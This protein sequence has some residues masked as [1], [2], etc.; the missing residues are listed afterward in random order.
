MAMGI[1]DVLAA[2]AAGISLTDTCVQTVKRYRESGVTLDIERLIEE[3]RITALLRIDEADLALAQFERTLK[4]RD[5]DLRHTLQQAIEATGFW[6]PFEAHR[7]KRMRSSFNALSDAAYSATDDIASLVRCRGKTAEMGTAVV[8]SSKR[9]HELHQDVLNAA[10]I[11]EAIA[12]LRA[13]LDRQKH[14]LMP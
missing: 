14:A 12:L 11:G 2:A 3:V 4:E 7:L 5:V 10:S 1:D 13:E 8:E 6:H 9:K